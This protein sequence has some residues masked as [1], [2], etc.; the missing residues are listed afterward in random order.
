MTGRT[1]IRE[2]PG[3]DLIQAIDRLSWRFET[4]EQDYTNLMEIQDPT[5]FGEQRTHR[6]KKRGQLYEAERRLHHFLAG[7]YSYDQLVET[8][9]DTSIEQSGHDAIYGRKGQYDQLDRANEIMGLRI[10]IQHNDILPLL[11]RNSEHSEDT[12]RFALNKS[13]LEMSGDDEYYEGFSRHYGHISGTCLYPFQ[14]IDEHWPEFRS[15]H[16]DIVDAVKDKNQQHI[17]EYQSRLEE[18]EEIRDEHVLPEF[19]EM[20]DRDS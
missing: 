18:L 20:M 16:E 8:L 19:R 15:F 6:F 5:L 2:L 13:E 7:Y 12:P 3:R 11:V 17:E 1:P 9:A 10:Y 4:L 14:T